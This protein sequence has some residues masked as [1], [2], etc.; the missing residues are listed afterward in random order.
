MRL[1]INNNSCS[2]KLIS[3]NIFYAFQSTITMHESLDTIRRI[4]PKV[5]DNL[6]IWQPIA[7]RTS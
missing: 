7:E 3:K 6:N 1:K 4:Q 5:S 2:A